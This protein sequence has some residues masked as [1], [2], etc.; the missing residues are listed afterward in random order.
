M[1]E[2]QTGNRFTTAF[3]TMVKNKVWAAARKVI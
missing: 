3:P 2:K 1:L